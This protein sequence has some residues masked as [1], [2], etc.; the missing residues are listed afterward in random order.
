MRWEWKRREIVIYE[1]YSTYLTRLRRLIISYL[2]VINSGTDLVPSV[3]LSASSFIEAKVAKV[4]S[5]SR[6][7][8]P[9]YLPISHHV[10]LPYIL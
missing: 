2:K 10:I 4:S 1:V 8:P 3:G 6:N 7:T 9:N 5:F